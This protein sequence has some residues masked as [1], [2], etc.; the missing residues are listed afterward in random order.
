ME[1]LS[2]GGARLRPHIPF[3]A[4]V[5]REGWAMCQAA[6]VDLIASGYTAV[7]LLDNLA[8]EAPPQLGAFVK[9]HPPGMEIL[10]LAPDV[11]PLVPW[12]SVYSTCDHVLVIAPECDRM[13][14]DALATF[15][16]GSIPT[17]NASISFCEIAGDKHRTA[18]R[19]H[20]AGIPHPP[21]CLLNCVTEAWLSMHRSN[22]GSWIVKPRD[23]VSADGA[24]R[25]TGEE[26]NAMRERESQE[27]AIDES[28]S[29][30]VQ[31][32]IKGESL[33]RSAIVRSDGSVLWLP[34]ARQQLQW[35][36]TAAYVGGEIDPNL[37]QQSLFQ[38]RRAN[39]GNLSLPTEARRLETQLV[40][41]LDSTLSAIDAQAGGWIG[42]DFLLDL[43]N[44]AHPF[45]IIEINPRLTTSFVGLSQAC[46]GGLLAEML[47]TAETSAESTR[48]WRAL[49]F[50]ADGEIRFS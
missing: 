26:L 42:I 13:L 27:S 21:T 8:A 33:S 32:W 28:S 47:G 16:E 24:I 3:P 49:R 37:I 45:T 4:G 31:P 48:K 14:V 46:G 6:L 11:D 20:A 38:K 40:E 50:T 30:I 35:Q 19:L 5:H 7:C 23:G 22:S 1:W 29:L 12:R 39:R 25:C 9:D 34:I 2:S 36:P 41:L 43:G 18:E 17:L 10:S 15:R 44:K